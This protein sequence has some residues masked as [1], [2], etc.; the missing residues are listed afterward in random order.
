M[1]AF[2][3]RF[4]AINAQSKIFIKICLISK[5]KLGADIMFLNSLELIK[6]NYAAFI[7][8]VRYISV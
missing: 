4:K 5:I 3:T 1:I 7:N 6:I 2:K 8:P